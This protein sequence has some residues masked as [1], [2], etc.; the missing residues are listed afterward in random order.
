MQAAPFERL[1]MTAV[2][3]WHVPL[4]LVALGVQRVDAADAADLRR[5]D[6]QPLVRSRERAVAAIEHLVGVVAAA[7]GGGEAGEFVDDGCAYRGGL[8]A[9]RVAGVLQVKLATLE[10]LERPAVRRVTTGRA[11][12]APTH[13]GRFLE[14]RVELLVDPLVQRHLP[15]QAHHHRAADF[16][17]GVAQDVALELG[18]AELDREP[19]HHFPH[20]APG[21]E[22][23][24]RL[25]EQRVPI[26]PPSAGLVA[27][28]RRQHAVGRGPVAHAHRAPGGGGPGH[29]GAD[30]S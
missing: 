7:A 16:V 4:A 21:T 29:R 18:L 11:G 3:A 19:T 25:D 27:G 2:G 23:V 15:R 9:R 17:D 13:G 6:L 14:Q 30:A 20:G 22:A 28:L 1:A 5:A 10:F 12:Q 8:Q 24:H 26:I